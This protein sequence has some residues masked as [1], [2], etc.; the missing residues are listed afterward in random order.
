MWGF[1]G[2]FVGCA[3]TNLTV[4]CHSFIIV[5]AIWWSPW[6]LKYKLDL[7]TNIHGSHYMF[8]SQ[9]E[10]SRSIGYAKAKS[11][12]RMKIPEACWT[13]VDDI[14]IPITTRVFDLRH[15]VIS[16]DGRHGHFTR[17]FPK[18]SSSSGSLCCCRL[19]AMLVCLT[20]GESCN[21]TNPS[22]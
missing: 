18:Y 15:W 17:P 21:A 6:T 1:W 4:S 10:T 19:W 7:E 22:D 13:I 12:Q 14:K 3:A 2:E 8:K 20:N 16:R 5:I 11:R 9:R